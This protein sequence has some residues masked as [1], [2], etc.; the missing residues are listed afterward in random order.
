MFDY[1]EIDRTVRDNG[2]PLLKIEGE[3]KASLL[4]GYMT[5]SLLAI[6]VRYG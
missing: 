4:R 2:L 1:E 6:H 3:E 5:R